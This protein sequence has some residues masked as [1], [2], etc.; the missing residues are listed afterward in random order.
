[1]RSFPPKKKSK[2]LGKDRIF[3][4]FLTVFSTKIKIKKQAA[5]KKE[6][7]GD[8]K[9]VF[10]FSSPKARQNS[11][12]SHQVM[13]SIYVHYNLYLGRIKGTVESSSKKFSV[14]YLSTME[15]RYKE[16]GYNKTLL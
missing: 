16:V 15:P 11:L 13:T 1:M 2:I 10:F 5:S 3:L 8:A 14:N 12:K 9:H 6:A 7:G 4:V